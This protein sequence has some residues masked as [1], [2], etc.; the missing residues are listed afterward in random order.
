MAKPNETYVDTA[1]GNPLR[2]TLAQ[3]STALANTTEGA[4]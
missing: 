4:T 2:H 1:D 3:H